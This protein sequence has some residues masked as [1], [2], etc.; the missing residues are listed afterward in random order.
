MAT[1]NDATRGVAHK[2]E[3]IVVT[4]EMRNSPQSVFHNA[5]AEQIEVAS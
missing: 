2:V 4:A 3:L 5:Q 1:D